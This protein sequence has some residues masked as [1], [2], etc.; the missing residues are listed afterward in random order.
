MFF[1][2]GKKMAIIMLLTILI[3]SLLLESFTKEGMDVASAVN[4]DAPK[5][6][7]QDQSS[8]DKQS[9]SKQ[10]SPDKQS[11]SPDGIQLPDGKKPITVSE[12]T[13]ILAKNQAVKDLLK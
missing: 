12:I 11:S 10:S 2:P 7:D 9:S 5:E 8:P 4:E 1:S 3:L 13:S 6:S